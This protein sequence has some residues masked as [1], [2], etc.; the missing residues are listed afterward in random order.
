MT[1]EQQ[2]PQDENYVIAHRREKLD[3]L[4]A[5]GQAFPNTFRRDTLAEFLVGS[6]SG[7]EAVSLEGET[8]QFR[9]AG[10]LVA[11]RVM[12]KASFVQL[13]DMSGRIQLFVQ[14]AAVGEG[15][16]ADFKTWDVGDIVGAAGT[17]F[18]TKTG[19]L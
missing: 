3:R 9:L 13:Q 1:D 7:R 12:G 15:L 8:Q 5:A 11:K 10:R 19:E 18:K 17:V 14:Q 6:Y 16:Y 4:R 2:P